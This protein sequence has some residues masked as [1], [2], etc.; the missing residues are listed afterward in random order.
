LLQDIRESPLY[1]EAKSLYEK[2]QQPGTEQIFDVADV[3]ASPDGKQ[4]VCAGTFA[5][6]A[7]GPSAS[8]ICQVDL[9]SGDIRVLTHGMCVDR[10]PSYS[11]DGRQISFLSDRLVSGVFQL[12]LLKSDRTGVRAVATVDGS[13][14]Y[15]HWS[16]DGSRILL[17]VAD[18]GADV[19]SIQGAI[20]GTPQPKKAL[21]TWMPTIDCGDRSIARR[22]IWIYDVAKDRARCVSDS[23][24]NVWEASWC[25]NDSV[26]AVVSRGASE[27]Q[28]YG[29][30]LRIIDIAFGASRELYAPP[31][32]LGLPC[33]SPSGARA[34]VIEALASDRFLV[35]GD[36]RLFDVLSGQMREVVT[37]GIDVTYLEWRSENHL[38]IAGHRGL[39]TV[40]GL[41]NCELDKLEEVWSSQALTTAGSYAT[42]SGIGDG[43]DCVLI[44]ESFLKAPEIATIRKG[45]YTSIRSLALAFEDE[46]QALGSMESLNW[47]APDGLEVQGWLLRPTSE[48]PNA[49]VMVVHGGPVWHWRPIWLGSRAIHILLLL[50]C[51][52]AVFL[53]NPRGSSGRGQPFARMVLGSMGGADS[54]DL[55]SGIDHLVSRGIADPDRLGIT[56][57]S[58]GGFMSCW[59]ITQDMRFR[60][61]VPVAPFTNHVSQILMSNVPEFMSIFVA[62]TYFNPGSRFFSGSPIMHARKARTATMS[63]CGS[64]D[65]CTPSAEAVQFHNALV[66][67]QVDSVLVTYPEEGHGIRAIPAML[68]FA[69]RAVGWFKKH[70]PAT[71]DDR[72]TSMTPRSALPRGQDIP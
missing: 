23:A 29:A 24:D 65:R 4:A 34:A 27:G 41:Y 28:W 54:Q 62:D 26:V 49:L 11:P 30:K 10:M 1:L 22:K 21:P 58:Y 36:C 51:G 18:H 37:H 42:V 25:G 16:P 60:A 44:G 40:V 46:I 2:L 33:A 12:C 48:G 50:K 55:L 38:L 43:G 17:G 52:Y 32:Q 6:S 47:N 66:S 20:K 5:T 53:P 63:I 72:P 67:N 71:P 57:V 56:G 69:A 9:I 8:R 13:V 59:L 3:R 7:D 14:E 15:A 64:L 68:D 70:M 61:S 35:A 31:V 19:G 45:E 39:E